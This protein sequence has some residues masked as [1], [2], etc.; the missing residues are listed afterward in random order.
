LRRGKPFR[1]VSPTF[2]AEIFGDF[3]SIQVIE[4]VP[5]PELHDLMAPG[6]APLP[7]TYVQQS[8]S[9]W[10]WAACGEMLFRFGE[11][12]QWTQCA[13]ASAQ[14]GLT[15]CSDLPD[16]CDQGCWP[17]LA[18]PGHGLDTD[19]VKAPLSLQEVRDELNDGRPVQ[20]CY[21]WANTNSTHVALIV[22]EYSNG[23]FEV[24][25]PAAIYG[26]RRLPFSQI[27]NAYSLGQWIRS[28][29]FGRPYHGV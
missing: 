3:V 20:V 25:D 2:L 15:C 12:P 13:L 27:E 19:M 8:Q 14:F 18:Y 24:F 29:K 6:G 23:E 26:R 17:H 22:G 11:M 10:C 5:L 21:Q 4:R 28:F 16:G 9:N 7:L 1:V